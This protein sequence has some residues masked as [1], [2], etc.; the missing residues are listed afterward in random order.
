MGPVI[1][2]EYYLGVYIREGVSKADYFQLRG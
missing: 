2:E 1:G